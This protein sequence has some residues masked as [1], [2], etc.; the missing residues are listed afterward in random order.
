MH[1]FCVLLILTYGT[2]SSNSDSLQQN[3][4]DTCSNPWRV[5]LTS[6]KVSKNFLDHMVRILSLR[7]AN[8]TK[9]C[10]QISVHGISVRMKRH[11]VFIIE[12]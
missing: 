1:S 4:N 5:L 3:L 6:I 12:N 11:I 7:E 2:F 8:S 9:M 10:E